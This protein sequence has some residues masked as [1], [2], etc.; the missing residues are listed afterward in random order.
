MM[1]TFGAVLGGTGETDSLDTS[2]SFDMRDYSL[3]ANY[4]SIKHLSR[5]EISCAIAKCRKNSQC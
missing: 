3:R 2:G 4:L 1:F 5:L